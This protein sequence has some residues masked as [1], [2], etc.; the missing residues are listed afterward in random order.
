MSSRRPD[1][2]HRLPKLADLVAVSC[3]RPLPCS[4]QHTT[5]RVAPVGSSPPLHHRISV[6][7]T[8]GPGPNWVKLCPSTTSAARPLHP[9]ERTFPATRGSTELCHKQS[10]L[11]CRTTSPTARRALL[12]LGVPAVRHFRRA[13]ASSMRVRSVFSAVMPGLPL[14]LERGPKSAY[15]KITAAT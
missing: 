15:A 12:R 8:T 4:I 2:E 5:R 1:A 3:V 14:C 11:M 13:A 6:A 9:I 7:L 10:L